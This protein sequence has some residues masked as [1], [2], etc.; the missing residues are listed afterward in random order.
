MH[1]I[2]KRLLPGQDL[3]L[4]IEKIVKENNIKAGVVLSMVGSLTI[5][6][7]RV[8]DGKTV[9]EWSG[10]FEI[11]S[12]TGTLAQADCHIHIS[13]ADING[14]IIGGHLKD[15]CI[16]GTTVEIVLL[17]FEDIEYKRLLDPKTGYN[18]LS[19]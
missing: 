7:L 9:K 16:I 10:Q 1:Q 15:R 4:E 6:R 18:E 13:A 11:V 12:A 3:R 19:N 17:V 5:L 14:A 2:T 8:A